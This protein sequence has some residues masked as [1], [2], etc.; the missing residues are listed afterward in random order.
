MTIH[1]LPTHRNSEVAIQNISR[2]ARK[3]YVKG[4]KDASLCIVAA[5][6]AG[7]CFG[8]VATDQVTLRADHSPHGIESLQSPFYGTRADP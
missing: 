6:L 5:L 1:T 7:F 3:G 8:C 2:F 4:W